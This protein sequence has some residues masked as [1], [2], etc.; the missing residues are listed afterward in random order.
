MIAG[1][2]AS[3]QKPFLLSATVI[4]TNDEPARQ[5]GRGKARRFSNGYIP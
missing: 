2:V 3:F 5:I 4:A 1:N